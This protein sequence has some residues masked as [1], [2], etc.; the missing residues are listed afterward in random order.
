MR[1]TMKRFTYVISVIEFQMNLIDDFFDFFT[2]P[3]TAALYQEPFSNLL[4]DIY[5]QGGNM[6]RFINNIDLGI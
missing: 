3:C 4:E 5:E 6:V 2:K 1:V